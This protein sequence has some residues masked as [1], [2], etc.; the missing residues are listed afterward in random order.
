MVEIKINDVQHSIACRVFIWISLCYF[1]YALVSLSLVEYFEN[2][3]TIRAT[4]K[5]NNTKVQ[6]SRPFVW[7]H[8][9]KI[10]TNQMQM[11]MHVPNT[12][13]SFFF[14]AL[15]IVITIYLESLKINKDLYSE[16]GRVS[17]LRELFC[18]LWFFFFSCGSRAKSTPLTRVEAV[19][20]RNS[21]SLSLSIPFVCQEIN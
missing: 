4:N 15:N 18:G 8:L 2:K 3:W 13:V 1:L 21:V 19:R 17:W 6:G 11:I 16:T 5:K 20:H 12:L 10:K 9:F 14:W 7:L